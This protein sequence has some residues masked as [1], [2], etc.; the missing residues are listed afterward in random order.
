TVFRPLADYEKAL[1]ETLCRI[2]AV[3]PSPGFAEVLLPGEP[4][5]RTR[6]ERER[7]GIPIPDDTWRA[8]CNVGVELGVNIAGFTSRRGVCSGN[9][10]QKRV[11]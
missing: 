2:K 6:A 3:P 10:T 11:K 7:N 1:T 8:V 4:E 5:A 9:V